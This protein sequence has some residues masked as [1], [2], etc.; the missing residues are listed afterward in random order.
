[1]TYKVKDIV[2]ER[3][4]FDPSLY[5]YYKIYKIDIYYYYYGLNISCKGFSQKD[6]F[7]KRT[8]LVPKVKCV[9]LNLK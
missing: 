7:E 4:N 9:L 6:Y 1:M 5:C 2:I 3:Y 8:N